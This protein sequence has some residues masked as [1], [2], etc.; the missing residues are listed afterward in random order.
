MFMDAG[1]IKDIVRE[2]DKLP[3]KCIM[4]DGV[5]GV[6]KTYAIDEVLDEQKNCCKISMFGLQN[7]QQIYH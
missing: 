1:R 3:Y 6:G 2:L 5:W 4:F 7:S